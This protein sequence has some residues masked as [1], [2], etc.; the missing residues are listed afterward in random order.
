MSANS[1]LKRAFWVFITTS[2]VGIGY[3][4]AK[5]YMALYQDAIKYLYENNLPADIIINSLLIK[6][7]LGLAV[8]YI[9]TLSASAIYFKRLSCIAFLAS[10]AFFTTLVLSLA[11]GVGYQ[12]LYLS[13]STAGRLTLILMP[14]I[15][16]LLL[17]VLFI[18]AYFPGGTSGV[19]KF[20]NNFKGS[21]IK[22]LF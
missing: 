1:I 12:L 11:V 15:L 14:M 10:I 7:K 8:L 9:V 17:V 5:G 6:L 3:C 19:L 4:S 20:R 22:W 18:L 2:I 21:N 13:L 16:L